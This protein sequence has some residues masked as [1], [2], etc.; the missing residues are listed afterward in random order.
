M[1][2]NGSGGRQ[3]ARETIRNRAQKRSTYRVVWG[4]GLLIVAAI[5]AICIVCGV[6]RDPPDTSVVTD[7]L[8]PVRDVKTHVVSNGVGGVRE[9]RP[10]DKA[11]ALA[12]MQEQAKKYIKKALTNNVIWVTP[13]L[14]PDDPDRALLTRQSCEIA[15][16]LAVQ[17]GEQLIPFPYSFLDENESEDT[18]RKD[19][20]NKE[21]L[22]AMKQFRLKVKE[23]DSDDRVAFKEKFL[24]A[25][26]EIL[27]AMN[28]GVNVNDSLRA[29]YEFRVRAY[30]TRNAAIETMREFLQ[31]GDDVEDTR[32]VLKQINEKFAEDGIKAITEEEIGIENGTDEEEIN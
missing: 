2:W 23:A 31:S 7:R 1:G 27:S 12:A 20:G 21:F 26:G 14:A 6:R 13:P 32:G 30:E 18:P 24:T 28:E 19:N 10:R 5:A 3:E 29:A 17:P 11:E 25:Q 16:L 8:R 9:A 4:L 15:A 22:D